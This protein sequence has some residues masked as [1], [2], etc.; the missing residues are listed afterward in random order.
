MAHVD[1]VA[2]NIDERAG[3]IVVVSTMTVMPIKKAAE[4]A[5]FPSIFVSIFL[6]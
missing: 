3:K 6:D 1:H 5:F 2:M 4:A